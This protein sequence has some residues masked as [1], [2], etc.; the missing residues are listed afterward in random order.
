MK[1]NYGV[2]N[3]FQLPKVIQATKEFAYEREQQKKKTKFKHFGNPNF[4]NTKQA[5]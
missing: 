5:S 3:A 4:N 2:E 1:D